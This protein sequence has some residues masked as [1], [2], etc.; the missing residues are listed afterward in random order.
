MSN[1]EYN[2]PSSLDI[3]VSSY[4]SA[5]EGDLLPAPEKTGVNTCNATTDEP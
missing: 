3:N 4:K 1:W 5:C 2:C